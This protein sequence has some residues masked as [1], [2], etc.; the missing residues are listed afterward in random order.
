[1]IRGTKME[2]AKPPTKQFDV[3]AS[4]HN[5]FDVEVVDAKTGNIKQRAFAE[6]VICDKLWTRLCSSNKWNTHVHYGDGQ[7]T[8]SSGDTT[9]FSFVGWLESSFHSC[10]YDYDNDVYK[11]TKK[12][13][14]SESVAAGKTLTEVGIAYGTSASSLVT[15]AMLRD[16]NG[17]PIS[18]EKSDTDIV[19]IYTTVFC[20]F[21]YPLNTRV[22]GSGKYDQDQWY[23]Y[24]FLNH[25]SG[26]EG[27][28]T[29]F[30]YPGY[31]YVP[32][33]EMS[34]GSMSIGYDV[35]NRSITFTAPRAGATNWNNL[36]GIKSLYLGATNYKVEVAFDIE[37]GTEWFGK[38]EIRGE[39]IGNGDGVTRDFTTAFGWMKT[40]KVYV[41]GVETEATW[42]YQASYNSILAYF[43]MVEVPSQG[44]T[45]TGQVSPFFKLG[46][47][48]ASSTEYRM[49]RVS[50]DLDKLATLENTLYET[51]GI[52]SLS[53]Y[54]DKYFVAYASQDLV[55]WVEIPYAGS[56]PVIIP[57]E[58]RRYRYWKFHTKY[59]KSHVHPLTAVADAELPL[60]SN[61]HL[62]NPPAEGSAITADYD[63]I[64]IGKD[65][66]HVF[67]FSVTFK[68]NEYTE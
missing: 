61:L 62:A 25:I 59:T 2:L 30:L 52:Y 56:S 13:V 46:S 12:A 53:P 42:D 11:V 45:K 9:L 28:P 51:V 43:R 47:D 49:A 5:R 57:E 64:C 6:N 3:G 60:P 18:L 36:G 22:L 24:T 16:M 4:I 15:H 1:M 21:T 68:F 55:D 67:D 66:N 40:A 54:W 32:C 17:N 38:T 34:L 31:G 35:S 63:A 7:G 39:S 20:H 33:G 19:N 44:Y 50:D 8:P 48:P 26:L 65:E 14:L 23:S 27:M 41:D 58:Y 37:D 29:M 10:D